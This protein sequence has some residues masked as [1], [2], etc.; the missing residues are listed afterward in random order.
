M[1][2]EIYALNWSTYQD[3]WSDVSAAERQALLGRAVAE[4]CTFES[5]GGAGRGLAQLAAHIEVFQAQ[6]PGASFK[7]HAMIAHHE[8]ALAE[9]MIY[10]QD[11]AECLSGKS[12]ARFGDDG[13]IRQLVG[14]WQA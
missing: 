13:R 2:K 1:E 14:F 3:A 12:Y 8:Q 6:Y 7:T 9:W 4:E 10:D 11:G 5:P